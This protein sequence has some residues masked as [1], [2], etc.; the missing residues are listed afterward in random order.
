MKKVTLVAITAGILW[1]FGIASYSYAGEDRAAV[2]QPAKQEQQVDRQ[3][4]SVDKIIVAKV[5][6][7]E[8][9]MTSLIAMM[10]SVGGQMSQGH[11]GATPDRE[12]IRKFAL[13]R[14]IL[15]ET[16]YQKAKAAGILAEQKNIDNALTN[17]KMNIGG[18]EEYKKFLEREKLTEGDLRAQVERRLVLE[19]IYAREVLDK[20]SVP[21]DKL[22]KEYEKE[23]SKFTAPEKI[24]LI[25][26]VI[27]SNASD[28]DTGAGDKAGEVLRK[29][30]DSNNDPWRLVLDGSFIV[31]AYEPKQPKD[32]ELIEVAR[33]MKEGEL[34]DVIK[35]GDSMHII[36]LE[37]YEP[38][39]Q[40]AFDEIRSAIENKFKAEAQ[41]QRMKEWS[42]ELKRNAK[43]E[44]LM[45]GASKQVDD[46]NQKKDG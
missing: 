26:V 37:K 28:K 11:G 18:E 1:G 44:I 4:L 10:N 46:K 32:S 22:K 39:K 19:T 12:E 30:K 21:E 3:Q 27:L 25:D 45:P 20:I 24:S 36:K 16:A 8:I 41:Q 9:T 6:G 5:N 40:L 15:Q 35:V 7:A 2:S 29:I 23:K 43:V 38:E 17:F 31:R 33:K 34:S 42:E 13:D 14:L